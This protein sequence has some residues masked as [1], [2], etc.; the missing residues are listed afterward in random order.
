MNTI[1]LKLAGF[2][3]VLGLL[4]G[5]LPGA[6]LMAA[7]FQISTPSKAINST[8][9]T[10]SGTA[11]AVSGKPMWYEVYEGI[12]GGKMIDFGAFRPDGQWSF[13]ARHL[14][15]GD[16]VVKVFAINTSGQTETSVITLTLNVGEDSPVR[17]RPKPA[18]VWWGGLGQNGQLSQP[19]AKWEYVKR[20]AD[21]YFMH[22]AIWGNSQDSILQ[23]IIAQTAPYGGK[24]VAELGGAIDF[25]DN[26]ADWQYNAWGANG[27]IKD[28]FNNAGA[29]L[30]E[31]THDTHAEDVQRIAKAFPS[32]N[33]AQIVDYFANGLYKPYWL[34]NYNIYPHL[35][36]SIT[37]SP[38]WWPWKQYPALGGD[39]RNNLKFSA[40]GR[41]YSIDCADLMNS[42]NNMAKSIEGHTPFAF[43]SDIPYYCSTWNEGNN[44]G[45][46]LREKVRAYEAWLQQTGARHTF[47]CIEDPGEDL[48]RQSKDAWDQKFCEN[49][50]KSLLLHQR[51]GGRPD[52]FLFES[53]YFVDGYA[54]PSKVT[55]EDQPN[56][57]T[58]LAKQGIKFIKGIKDIDGSLEKLTLLKSVSGNTTSITLRNDGESICFPA[59]VAFEQGDSQITARWNGPDGSDISAAIKSAE[60]WCYTTMLNAGESVTL[61]CTI[62]APGGYSKKF[63]VEAFWN[64]QDPTGVVRD[65]IKWTVGSTI[66]DPFI[67]NGTGLKGSYFGFMD[68]TGLK[69]TRTDTAVDFN[70][71]SGSPDTS[72][73][74]TKYSVRWEGYVQPKYTGDWTFTTLSDDGVRLW[75][76]GI[77]LIDNWTDHP[78]T[79]NSGVTSLTAGQRY[80]IKM[81]YFQNLGGARAKLSW[82]HPYLSKEIIPQTQ[83]YPGSVSTKSIPGKIEA[84]DYNTMSGVMT[85]DCVEGTLNVGW[86]DA[87][88]WMDYSV[89]VN[90]S[91]YYQLEL[92]V[93]SPAA[94]GVSEILLDGSKIAT[95]VIP[96]TGNWQSWTSTSVS[97]NL[98][99]GNHTLRIIAA[100]GAW[101]INYINFTK[102]TVSSSSVVMSSSQSSI[103]SVSSTPVSS[104]SSSSIA[105][106]GFLKVQAFNGSTAINNNQIYP[107]L[108]L[109]NT[110]TSSVNLA[111]VKIRYY[112]TADGTQS[113]QFWFDWSP[114]GTANVTGTVVKISRP[115]ADTYLEVGFTAAAGNLNPGQAVEVQARIAKS[116][117][118]NFNQ[119]N[120]Y[121]FN[122][123]GSSY[124]DWAK[125]TAYMSG[126]IQ[127][128][129]EP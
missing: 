101:N 111:N 16:N 112:Y 60:G 24:L 33:E 36:H 105:A 30:S 61:T 96:N 78:P 83:L 18:E 124:I 43:F 7:A 4:A 86:I 93:A 20:F 13:L 9:V 54:M 57:Y 108:N 106:A 84:E 129:V 94:T 121:S 15:A 47:V 67:G 27:Y 95:V 59:L 104:S 76:N 5:F 49:G 109:V 29:I 52:R 126:S 35:K 63:I 113:Q 1:K 42:F 11:S 92:R 45:V 70:W 97:V 99:A 87:G 21:S 51:E 81:E 74:G 34:K 114:V 119:S 98:T 38:V 44:E 31:V 123:S 68:L 56:T 25:I 73:P 58:Y 41:N 14:S 8:Y 117:W 122:P 91:G 118:S 50:Y 62:N 89:L 125:T 53:W 2:L 110:G 48:G 32:M 12:A 88:D 40:N 69:L 128:G 39:K 115:N 46:V 100:G 6:K 103:K 102:D 28:R 37:S 10:V 107:R 64:P 80:S 75:V 3:F 66:P 79:E 90:Q 72:L 23:S 82:A 77:L 127:W 116:D 85:Q 17:P 65:R 55:P 22:T 26:W 19:G 120:D 71:D